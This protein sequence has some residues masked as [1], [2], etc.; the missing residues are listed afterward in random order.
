MK[1]HNR[2]LFGKV[3]ISEGSQ[4]LLK[5]KH[6]GAILLKSKSRNQIW[7]RFGQPGI[8]CQFVSRVIQNDA[9]NQ[10]GAEEKAFVQ[11]F[12]DCRT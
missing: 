9:E 11:R 1:F 4:F 3:A 2:T 7:G 6:V 8:F 12:K 10:P 5:Q